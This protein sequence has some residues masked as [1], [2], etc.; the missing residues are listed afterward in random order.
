MGLKMR[1]VNI[2]GVPQFKARGGW[3]VGGHK[4]TTYRENCL[5]RG[6]WTIWRGLS[7][8]RKKGVFQEGG[9]WVDTPMHTMT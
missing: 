9:G 8:T 7:K 2:M 4:K 5:K 1:N 3:E 6:A